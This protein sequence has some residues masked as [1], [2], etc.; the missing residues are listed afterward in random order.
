MRS[1]REQIRAYRFVT[2][3]IVT[4]LLGGDP[5][6]TDP[7]MR[8]AGLTT[9]ASAMIGALV[10]AGFGVYGL[11]RPGG[12][13]SW[14]QR[15]TLIVEKDTGTRFVYDKGALHPV[16]NYA[17]ARL[18]LKAADPP[19]V[20]VSA[21]SLAG[22]P[23][24]RP[25]GIRDA[26]DTLPTPDRLT[27][28]PWSVCSA[29]R[30]DAVRHDPMVSVALGHSFSGGAALTDRGVLVKAAGVGTYL[31]WHGTRLRIPSSSF[32]PFVS[33][34][35]PTDVA[36]AM[37]NA[38]PAGPDLVAPKIDGEGGAAPKVGDGTGR[39]GSVYKVPSAGAADMYFVLLADGLARTSQTV[40]FLLLNAQNQTD[41]QSLS[42]VEYK[43][44]KHSKRNLQVH[45][46][47]SVP[48]TP[49]N[50]PDTGSALCA[51]YRGGGHTTIEVYGSAPAAL[52]TR[53]DG[54]DDRTD[55][56]GGLTAGAVLVPGGGGAL[57]RAT[58]SAGVPT[59]TTYLVTDQGI[60]YGVP[61][62]DART[63]LGYEG[64]TPTSVPQDLLDLVPSGP[65]LDPKAATNYVSAAPSPSSTK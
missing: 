27:G 37:L 14:R 58:T 26:P 15:G 63:A 33:D 23:R 56:L 18:I 43:E 34:T 40:A 10:L 28:L 65:S 6:S 17:S 29:T 5:D 20:T 55:E 9:F 7:P 57:V 42:L 50:L 53:P 38:V 3:R 24:G 64:V 4:A 1:R 22:V 12:N 25:A 21:D 30:S 46:I 62:K 54:A 11:V 44:A 61:S 31:L 60:R 16:L 2:R 41:P 52:T 13:T 48:R 39:I 49:A 59:G 19:V 51:S 32:N 47:P 8:R 45:G 35:S 36:P